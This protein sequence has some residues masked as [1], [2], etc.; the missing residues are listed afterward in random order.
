MAKHFRK[1][2]ECGA[3]IS[4]CRCISDHKDVEII[5]HKEHLD[6]IHWRQEADVA[7][8][9]KPEP[10]IEEEIPENVA[11]SVPIFLDYQYDLSNI[12]GYLITPDTNPKSTLIYKLLADGYTFEI[13]GTIQDGQVL[14]VSIIP[15]TAKKIESPYE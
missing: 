8:R 15:H 7:E 2:C 1:E 4:Q 3:V 11:T 10:A 12:I 6:R 14:S 5:T 9:A 13:G